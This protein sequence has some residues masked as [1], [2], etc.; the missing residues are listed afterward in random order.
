M[1]EQTKDA[2]ELPAESLS[3]WTGDAVYAE[4]HSVASLEETLETQRHHVEGYMRLAHLEGVGIDGVWDDHDLGINDAGKEVRIYLS[5]SGFSQIPG[6]P[7]E[8][9]SMAANGAVSIRNIWI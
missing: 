1:V 4:N 5:G 7:T 8:F 2:A 6:D 9:R 3:L